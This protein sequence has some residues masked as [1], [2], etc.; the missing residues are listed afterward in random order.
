MRIFCC[1]FDCYP[2]KIRFFKISR[3][4]SYYIIYIKTNYTARSSHFI[5][6]EVLAASLDS[7]IEIWKFDL[8]NTVTSQI[9]KLR[10]CVDIF[11]VGKY[12]KVLCKR[13][14]YKFVQNERIQ[15]LWGRYYFSSPLY[16]WKFIV[17]N[18]LFWGILLVN[19]VEQVFWNFFGELM[20]WGC[21]YIFQKYYL[22]VENLCFAENLRTIEE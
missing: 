21:E 9:R 22:D 7:P 1:K 12:L 14:G 8:S 18:G 10:Y 20:F 6:W 5:L 2:G 16:S 15:S 4:T 17:S 19:F 11:I 3:S 13:I